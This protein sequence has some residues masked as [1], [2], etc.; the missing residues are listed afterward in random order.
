[1]NLDEIYNDKQIDN[2]SK[3][4]FLKLINA[5]Q[6]LGSIFELYTVGAIST[7]Q[8]LISSIEKISNKQK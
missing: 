4:S 5:L 7:G 6:L 3:S 1:M 8:K 2:K